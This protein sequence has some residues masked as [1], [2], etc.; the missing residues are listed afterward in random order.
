[1]VSG[2]H[3]GAVTV[4][5]MEKSVAWYQEN[6]GFVTKDEFRND[7]MHIVLLQ[8]G[9]ARLELFVLKEG[10]VLPDYRKSLLTDLGTVGTKHLAFQVTN[11]EKMVDK[12]K[13]KG[14]EIES[15]VDTAAFGGKYAFIKDT[16]GNLIELFEAN[17]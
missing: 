1:M 11:I 12:L 3:H 16:D 14:V 13:E 9:E 4:S 8:A 15:E 5:D 17:S 6:L 7:E 10:K 2:M